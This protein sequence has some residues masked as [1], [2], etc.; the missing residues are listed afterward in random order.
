[1]SSFESINY[2]LRPAKGVERKMLCDLARRLS[3]F[4][5]IEDYM[6]IGFGSIFFTDFVL[7]HKALGMQNMHSIEREAKVVN[8]A[9]LQNRFEF[10]KPF[11]CVKMHYGSATEHLPDMDWDTKRAIVWLDY[12]GKLENE[13]LA[14]LRMVL[15]KALP[16]SLVLLS[17]NSQ[18]DIL[19][20]HTEGQLANPPT[21][22]RPTEK[23][24]RFKELIS[25]LDEQYLP[26]WAADEN[27]STSRLPEAYH[28]ALTGV[29]NETLNAL[30][31]SSTDP[32]QA[33]QLINIRY[34]DNAEMMT[35]GWLLTTPSLAASRDSARFGDLG[36]ISRSVT[37]FKIQVPPLTFK[38]INW[39]DSILHTDIDGNGKL[40]AGGSNLR[41]APTLPQKLVSQY[42]TIYRY[43]PTFAEAV[44]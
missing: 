26:P 5:P 27:L 39:L 30:N 15:R 6:Y 25:R 8:D 43:F 35:I 3:V 12:D 44:L 2:S 7:F 10:N 23:E 21:E 19:P 11:S 37:P 40:K 14:D 38:E 4:G 31:G 17:V 22:K 13:H 32:I 42:V 36:F 9:V 24:F 16:G 1:M 18:P 28:Y 41:V 20:P 33:E 34:K 29:V